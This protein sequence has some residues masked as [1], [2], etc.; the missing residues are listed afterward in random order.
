LRKSFGLIACITV[1]I[2]SMALVD[3]KRSFAQETFPF[4][5]ELMLDAAPMRGSKRIPN[6]EIGRNGEVIIEL[7][8]KGARGQFS[9]AGETVVFVPGPVEDRGCPA[10]RAAADDALLAALAE[11]TTWRRQGDTLVLNGSRP[12]RFRLN[13]N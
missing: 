1:C 10:D 4:S 3:A 5:S 7:W 13:A 6:L 2:A 8:C 12:L 9:V 11:A